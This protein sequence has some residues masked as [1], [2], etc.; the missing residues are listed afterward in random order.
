MLHT[1]TMDGI[2]TAHV[3]SILTRPLGRVLRRMVRAGL[4]KA[5]RVSVLTR[6]LGRV[7][8]GGP[9]VDGAALLG[10]NP[11]PAVRPGAAGEGVDGDKGGS[12]VSILTRPLGRV[13]PGRGHATKKRR[14]A[15][16]NPHPAVRPGAAIIAGLR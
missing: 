11:H 10:F 7:L 8:L 5:E 15:G 12:G 1:F 9:D 6:P 2:F 4:D 14:R 13:L 3:V 16:F